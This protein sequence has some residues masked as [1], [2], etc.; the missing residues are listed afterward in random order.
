MYK[1][2]RLH[3]LGTTRDGCASDMMNNQWM[4]SFMITLEPAEIIDLL[5]LGHNIR[6]TVLKPGLEES[7]NDATFSTGKLYHALMLDQPQQEVDRTGGFNRWAWKQR[8]PPKMSFLIW[9]VL[10]NLDYSS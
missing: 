2:P 5:K 8:L 3:R 9:S 6:N 4:F 7:L 10:H 1:Y